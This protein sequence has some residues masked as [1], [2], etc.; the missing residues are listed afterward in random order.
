VNQ[1]RT[2]S[3][4]E[5]AA[6]RYNLK[7][8]TTMYN[9]WQAAV[10]QADEAL[11]MPQNERI[12]HFFC[13]KPEKPKHE[14]TNEEILDKKRIGVM[15]LLENTF[16][17]LNYYSDCFC[18]DKNV[19]VCDYLGPEFGDPKLGIPAKDVLFKRL[20]YVQEMLEKI[21]KDR[22]KSHGNSEHFKA[23][24]AILRAIRAIKESIPM[25]EIDLINR[26]FVSNS[27]LDKN[28]IYERFY[29]L[30]YK[31]FQNRSNLKTIEKILDSFYQ[32]NPETNRP[33]CSSEL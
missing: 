7:I 18:L 1:A 5:K 9:D 10:D 25:L 2:K 23:D 13:P 20:D 19:I 24:N 3:G 31:L 29:D 21:Y 4:K 15:A 27:D 22:I 26:Y 17:R 30:K 11:N 12:D 33:M 8:L 16:F 28:V 32:E 14:P 6:L